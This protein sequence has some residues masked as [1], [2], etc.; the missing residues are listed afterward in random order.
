MAT[1]SML[2]A[3]PRT[4]VGTANSK[5]LRSQGRIPASL[6]G[7]GREPLTI[8]LSSDA[9]TPVLMAGAHVVDV[10][11][12]G[13]VEMAMIR[14]VQWDT[15]LTHIL[16]LDLLRIDREARIDVDVAIDVR[17]TL[18][19][20]VLDQPLHALT[21]SCQAHSVP[22]RFSV[23]IGSLKIDDTVTVSDLELPEGTTT[24]VPGDTVVLR[25]NE[26]QDIDIEEDDIAAAIE[27]EVIGAKP[28]DDEGDE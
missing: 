17:G 13:N 10:E 4:A 24:E 11:L 5:R 14:E 23:R 25:V 20:G 3:Q 16:H 9:A 7:L 15:F 26:I 19:E 21:L 8:S 2:S 1:T 12:D 6:Y 27:P 18:N 22:D 28:D